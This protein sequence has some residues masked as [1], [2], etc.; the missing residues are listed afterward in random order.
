VNIHISLCIIGL[1]L[2]TFLPPLVLSKGCEHD[3]G[4]EGECSTP[5]Y[6][7]GYRDPQGRF[8]SIMAFYCQTGQ[9][10]GNTGKGSCSRTQMFSNPV[11]TV[12]GSPIGNAQNDNARQIDESKAIVAA[13]FSF[14]E[15]CQSNSDCT[16]SDLCNPGFCDGVCSF[17]PLDC[18]YRLSTV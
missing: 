9:C 3:R 8:R 10:D 1:K 13:Y 6:N 14:Q 5:G 12:N 16:T 2:P 4:A 17:P 18:E 11:E 7:Y 15:Q